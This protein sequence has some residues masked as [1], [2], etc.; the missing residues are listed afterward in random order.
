M[1]HSHLVHLSDSFRHLCEQSLHLIF[2]HAILVCRTALQFLIQTS[3]LHKFL[4]QNKFFVC[5]EVRVEF[6]KKITFKGT[7]ASNFIV[8]SFAFDSLNLGKLVYFEGNPLFGLLVSCQLDCG[9]SSRTKDSLLS[10]IVQ[11]RPNFI[12]IFVPKNLL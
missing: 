11:T 4:H 9:V 7:H 12:P 5:F 6:G 8:D 10:E 3:P 2:R 1:N